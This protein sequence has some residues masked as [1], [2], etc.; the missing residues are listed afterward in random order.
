[1]GAWIIYLIL[2]MLSPDPPPSGENAILTGI[3]ASIVGHVLG[4]AGLA[5]F[6]IRRSDWMP[7]MGGLTGIALGFLILNLF[8]IAGWI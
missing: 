1:M 3:M 4:F 6:S 8:A 7:I 5:W 2:A